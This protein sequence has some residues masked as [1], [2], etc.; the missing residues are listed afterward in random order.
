MNWL[1]CSKLLFTYLYTLDTY[2][3]NLSNTAQLTNMADNVEYY[4]QHWTKQSVERRR[5]RLLQA[6]GEE[7]WVMGLSNEQLVH[8]LLVVEEVLEGQIQKAVQAPVP[9]K[10]TSEFAMLLRQ[11]EADRKERE[12]AAAAA[13][14]RY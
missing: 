2:F 8:Y 7:K 13:E 5:K 1:L 14:R 11:M 10:D 9:N 3:V 6:G 12:V 4:R